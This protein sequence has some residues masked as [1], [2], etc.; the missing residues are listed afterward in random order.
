MT[1]PVCVVVGVGE[2]NGAALA[3]AFAREGMRLALLARRTDYSA[4]LAE[5]IGDARPYACDVSDAASVADAFAR[6]RGELGD[7][8]TVIYNAG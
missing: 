1:K 3:R 7:P 8:S 4:A 5:E 6:I 2:G